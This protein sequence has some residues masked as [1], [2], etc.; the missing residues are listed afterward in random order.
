MRRLLLLVSGLLLSAPLLHAQY[1]KQ[2]PQN[3]TS[4]G[5]ARMAV[6]HPDGAT[7]TIQA[8]PPDVPSCPVGM[9]ARQGTGS[10]LIAVRDGH[11]SPPPRSEPSQRIHLVLRYGRA[12]Q[13]IG[14]MV[15]VRG[16]SGKNRM[17]RA[18]GMNGPAPDRTVTLNAK[19]TPESNAEV[20]ADLVLA[21]FTSVQTID[22]L[23]ISY[24]DGST[25]KMESRNACRVAPDLMM[26]VAGR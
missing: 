23:S 19:F 2:V 5:Q 24:K 21:G 7:T 26:L 15:R 18:D 10:G 4:F 14:A 9:Q 6:L 20:A 16:L 22:L 17:Q 8:A 1:E 12:A 25:W 13:V 3:G 11:S